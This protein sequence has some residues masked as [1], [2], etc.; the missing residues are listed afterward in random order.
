MAGC[1]YP[2]ISL[3]ASEKRF[4]WEEKLLI[5]LGLKLLLG[6]IPPPTWKKSS[7]EYWGIID[8]SYWIYFNNIICDKLLIKKKPLWCNFFI[9]YQ[10]QA[11]K[12]RN[13]GKLTGCGFFELDMTTLTAMAEIS[14]TYIIVLA[15]NT[16]KWSDLGIIARE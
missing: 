3:N 16:W 9:S 7:P 5:G 1:L 10:R 6:R 2:I 11:E 14:L 12:M 13:H 15:Q 8:Q 4:T